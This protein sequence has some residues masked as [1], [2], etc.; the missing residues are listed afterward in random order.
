M[1]KIKLLFL[2]ALLTLSGATFAQ[3]SC[4][5]IVGYYPSW[6]A[7]GNYYIN[8]PSKVDY[9]KYTHI[10]YAFA[11]PGSDGKDHTI[12]NRVVDCSIKRRRRTCT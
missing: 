11:I 3:V 5:N 7:G 1:Q 12:V 6:V 2:F 8:S 9:S 4:Y 10:C